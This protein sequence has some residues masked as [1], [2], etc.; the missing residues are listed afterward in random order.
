MVAERLGRHGVD[1]IK[2]E[3]ESN[4]KGGNQQSAVDDFFAARF[5]T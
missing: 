1:V 3:E 5:G 2:P 4:A